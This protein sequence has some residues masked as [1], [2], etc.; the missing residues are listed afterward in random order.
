ME[1]FSKTRIKEVISKT[2]TSLEMEKQR[3]LWFDFSAK[4]R[5]LHF[6]NL[7]VIHF[8]TVTKGSFREQQLETT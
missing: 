8:S 5:K 1:I 7:V 2:S 4:K 6:Y 3:L